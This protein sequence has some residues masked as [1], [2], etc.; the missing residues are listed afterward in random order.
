MAM[1]DEI[2]LAI[3][4]TRT[5]SLETTHP[6]SHKNCSLGRMFSFAPSPAEDP[7]A[8]S[9]SQ[10]IDRM[11]ELLE[12]LNARVK[13]IEGRQR[14]NSIRRSSFRRAPSCGGEGS[15]VRAAAL[16]RWWWLSGADGG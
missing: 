7:R 6:E 9:S 14:T 2:A 13:N 1:I 3:K 15:V 5:P 11:L 8:G 10:N 4:C 12:D 16:W